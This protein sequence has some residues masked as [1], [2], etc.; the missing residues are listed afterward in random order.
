MVPPQVHV[1]GVTSYLVSELSKDPTLL[2]QLNPASFEELV[3]NRL[4][5][6][7]FEVKKVGGSTYRKD[8]GVDAL[9]W[10]RNFVFPFLLAVQVKFKFTPSALVGPEPVRDLAGVMSTH[11]LN[12]GMIVTNTSFSPDAKWFA[13]KQPTLLH[14]RDQSALVQWLRNE[15]LKEQE[16]RPIPRRIEL[17]NGVWVDLS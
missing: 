7:G 6:M 13:A 3:F 4:D 1:I 14:L 9:A 2:F 15:F 8:G 5:L 12:A 17:C 11:N 16:W 10:P